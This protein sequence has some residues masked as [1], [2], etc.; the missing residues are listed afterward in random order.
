MNY[1]ARISVFGGREI[2]QDTYLDAVEIGTLLAAENYLVYCGGGEGVM[3]AI[4]KGVDKCGGTCI[5]IL[6]GTDKSEANNYIHIPISTGAGIGRNVILAY[7]CD[8]AV[9]IS[10]KYGTLSEI[11]FAFQLEKPV[12]GYGTWDL[13]DIHN[14]NTP[15]DVI[16]KVGQLLNGK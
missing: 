15:T 11:A 6:K 7:N 3:E 5:G 12:V 13:E 8:V 1:S 4:A 2:D 9:A 14:A 10:G 16:D